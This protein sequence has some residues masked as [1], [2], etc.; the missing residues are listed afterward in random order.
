[1]RLDPPT[2]TGVDKPLRR[3][4]AMAYR[5]AREA[6]LSHH[7][8]LAPA[9]AIYCEAHPETSA[10]VLAASARINETI[11]SA[12]SVGHTW[13]WKNVRALDTAK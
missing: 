3:T 10:D 12:I 7:D 6:G 9:T 8:A 11:A 13:F 1:M 5:T 4:V 2:V